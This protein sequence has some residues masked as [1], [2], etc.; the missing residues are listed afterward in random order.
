MT[1]VGRPR[2]TKL[3]SSALPQHLVFFDTETLNE[4]PP[5]VSFELHALRLGVAQR[6]RLRKGEYVREDEIVFRDAGAFWRWL[7]N[8]LPR[9]GKIVAI[10][11]NANFDLR[12]IDLVAAAPRAGFGWSAEHAAYLADP[13]NAPAPAQTEIPWFSHKHLATFVILHHAKGSV[14]FLDSLNWFAGSA[15]SLGAK[16][17]LAKLTMPS[18]T[19]PDAEWETYCR[20]DVEIVAR[21]VTQFFVACKAAGL[22][23]PKRT[24]ASTAF[25]FYRRRFLPEEIAIPDVPGTR[26]FHRRAY[27]GGRVQ[28]GRVG[29]TGGAVDTWDVKSLYPFMMHRNDFPT[30]FRKRWR[31]VTP[32]GFAA[33]VEQE[34]CIADVELETDT[35][36]FPVRIGGAVKY[37]TGAFRTTLAAPELMVA[38][39]TGMIRRVHQVDTFDSAPLFRDYVDHFFRLKSQAEAEGDDLMRHAWKIILNSL[40]GK[41]GQRG[42]DYLYILDPDGRECFEGWTFR[43]P[44]GSVFEEWER[45]G[46]VKRIRRERGEAFLSHPAIAAFVT[47]FARVYVGAAIAWIGQRNLIYSDT[48]SV[49]VPAGAFDPSELPCHSKHA[50]LGRWEATGAW[51]DGWIHGPKDY[52]LTCAACLRSRR[53]PNADCRQCHGRGYVG[54]T[55]GVRGRHWQLTD[56]ELIVALRKE[57]KNPTIIDAQRRVGIRQQQFRSLAAVW[58]EGWSSRVR[59]ETITKILSRRFTGGIIEADGWTRPPRLTMALQSHFESVPKDWTNW[60]MADRL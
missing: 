12:T 24:L 29:S 9:K 20:R 8:A 27:Y 3:K 30:K 26:E 2:I 58:H 5:N 49:F 46:D 15:E 40:Y 7:A 17:G 28:V 21:V 13:D 53:P 48:D 10:C 43:N 35:F 22:G 19:A 57:M 55:K 11:H 47:S 14:E 39:R 37:C 54:K 45:F 4:A 25:T 1:G 42:A 59:I 41:F 38:A 60:T 44:D 36:A 33:L 56:E 51:N 6:W 18:F 31:S 16:A 23:A 52:Q 50:E 32:A 34:A